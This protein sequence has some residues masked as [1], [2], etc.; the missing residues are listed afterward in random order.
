MRLTRRSK[1][2]IAHD[3]IFINFGMSVPCWRRVRTPGAAD[4][5][6]ASCDVEDPADLEATSSEEAIVEAGA[7]DP[8]ELGPK[9]EVVAECDWWE[10]A[11]CK[12]PSAVSGAGI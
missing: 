12:P 11:T 3:T 2:T 1:Q 4:G 10:S 9:G 7:K 8:L 6:E 5:F